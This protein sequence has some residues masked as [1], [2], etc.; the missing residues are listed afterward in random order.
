MLLELAK[1]L[2]FFLSM[3]SL[4]PVLMS[5]FF[6]PGTHW[7]E[8]LAMALLK[9]A[10]AGCICFASGLLF[11]WPSSANRQTAIREATQ[12]LLSTLPVR[13]FFWSTIGMTILFAAS[14]YLETYYVPVAQRS[15]CRL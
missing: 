3:I 2:T 4:Y 5:A 9:V 14:W 12:P 13:L 8:R 1:A 11:S 10:L 7:E 15:C 6:L